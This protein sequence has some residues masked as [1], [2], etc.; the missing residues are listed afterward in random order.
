MRILLAEDERTI[1]VT[2]RDDLADRGHDVWH[3]ADGGEAIDRVPADAFDCVISDL[4]LP[5]ADGLRVLAA[6]RIA[7]P[8]IAAV[9]ITALATPAHC[10]ACA[11]LRAAFV[12]KPFLNEEILDLVASFA[13][14]AP[15][16]APTQ[17]D[18][19]GP[20]HAGAPFISLPR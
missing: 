20:R 4:R 14:L 3:V 7:H 5:G 13:G 1:A 6:A 9:L 8:E 11:A 18:D 16:D 12:P 10:A 2:L 15:A 19:D 17:S